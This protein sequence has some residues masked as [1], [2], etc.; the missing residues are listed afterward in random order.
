[1]LRIIFL[2]LLFQ[3][4]CV[5]AN[6]NPLN[7]FLNGL[8]TIES[9]FSQTLLNESG[10][11]IENS[12]GMLYLRQPA[13]F[14]WSY[15]LPYSQKIISD[16]NFLWIYDEDLEQVTIRNIADDISQT[17]AGIILGNNDINE[18]F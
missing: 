3:F 10:Q 14:H 18:H 1:M 9:N 17:P 12:S 6:E 5:F 11:V 4:H 8:E 7:N 2:Y 13:K 15:E 16:G